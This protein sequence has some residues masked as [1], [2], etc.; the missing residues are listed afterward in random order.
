M[1]VHLLLVDDDDLLRTAVRRLLRSVLIDNAPITI[2]DFANVA[3]ALQWLSQ[4]GNQPGMILS[5]FNMPGQDGVDFFEE[6][7][8]RFGNKRPPFAF[9]SGNAFATRLATCVADNTLDCV[10]KPFDR[11]ELIDLLIKHL[12]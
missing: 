10:A 12:Q 11:Q 3:E 8:A 9:Y 1:Y 2:L 4:D 6:V 7:V 5:D